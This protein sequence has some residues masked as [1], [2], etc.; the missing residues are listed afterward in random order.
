MKEEL[1]KV[2]AGHQRGLPPLE[3]GGQCVL[4]WVININLNVCTRVGNPDPESAQFL[5]QF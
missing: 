1:A 2:L 4:Q 5:G 3:G